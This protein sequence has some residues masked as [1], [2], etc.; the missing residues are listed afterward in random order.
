MVEDIYGNESGNLG[1]PNDLIA[2]S[3]GKFG[4]MTPE[5]LA[6]QKV[7][8]ISRSLITAFA[9]NVVHLTAVFLKKTG[10]EYAVILAD[11]FHHN[12]FYCLVQVFF[13]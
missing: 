1:L 3:L 6:E 13:V 11:S 4:K 9:I 5:E 12:R 10:L 8:D 2:S 7:E